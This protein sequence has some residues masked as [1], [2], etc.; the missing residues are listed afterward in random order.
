MQATS[1]LEDQRIPAASPGAPRAPGAYPWVLIGLLW[2]CAFLNNGD[3]SLLVAV[4]P[5]IR[6][7]FGLTNTQLA[8]PTT[9]FFWVYA[10]AVFLTSRFGDKMHRSQVILWGLVFWSIATGLVGLSTGFVMLI[11]T[12]ALVAVGEATYY[13][14]AT[15]LISDWH[16]G[17]TRTRALSIHQTGVFAGA[18]LGSLAAGYIAD[19][20][21][22]RAPFVIFAGVGILYAVLL[23]RLL[24]D[25][26]GRSA[27]LAQ[28]STSEPLQLVLGNK[29]ALYLCLV[30]LLG[31]ATANGLT[32]WAP[33]FVHDKLH[34]NLANSA[35][36]GS[37]P[38]NIAGIIAVPLGGLLADYLCRRTTLGRFYTLAIGLTIAGIMLLPMYLADSA[39]TVGLVLLLST[40]GKGLFDGCIY[41]AMHDVVPPEARSTAVGV[42][43]MAGFVGAGLAPLFVAATSDALGMGMALTSLAALYFVAVGVLL[44]TRRITRA[45]IIPQ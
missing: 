23:F 36:V 12:R 8:L 44:A 17:K 28:H 41:A 35:L 32:V 31:T 4:M 25:A 18:L 11:G 14:S 37:V 24:K 19:R 10:I 43:T 29:P 15:A 33:T 42:M 13:P 16:S 40:L 45:A 1:G 2:C 22:W 6:A 38:I 9:I 34:T 39:W 21:G 7:E 27:Q 20:M 5:A 3:R 30:F 26:P